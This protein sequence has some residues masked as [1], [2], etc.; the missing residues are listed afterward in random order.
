LNISF[1][2]IE[3]IASAWCCKP[4]QAGREDSVAIGSLM[5]RHLL[6]VIVTEPPSTTGSPQHIN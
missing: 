1:I 3:W 5:D 2:C 4:F 6:I